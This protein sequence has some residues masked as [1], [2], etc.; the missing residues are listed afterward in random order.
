MLLLQIPSDLPTDGGSTNWALLLDAITAF[1]TLLVCVIAIWGETIQRKFA[2]PRLVIVICESGGRY[3]PGAMC[4]MWHLQVVNES[5]AVV[6]N[7]RVFLVGLWRRTKSGEFQKLPMTVHR[8]FVWAPAETEPALKTFV[9]E[10]TLDFGVVAVNGKRCFEPSLYS[11]NN[12][13]EGYVKPGECVRYALVV[14]ADNHPGKL[15]H[16][17]IEWFKGDGGALLPP[18]S[19]PNIEIRSVTSLAR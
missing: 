7:C 11:I 17:E 2:G 1:G 3:I 12:D 15:S 9:T 13:F 6:K 10:A 8:Q 14:E 18:D 5:R 4:Y 19:N 16:F